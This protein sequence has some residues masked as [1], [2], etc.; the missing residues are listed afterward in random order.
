MS[1]NSGTCFPVINAAINTI[2]QARTPIIEIILLEL[3]PPLFFKNIV[4]QSNL[5]YLFFLL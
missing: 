1:P 3:I 2:T 5:E 4:R